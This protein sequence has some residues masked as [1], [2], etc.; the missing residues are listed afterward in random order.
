[1]IRW[2]KGHFEIEFETPERIIAIRRSV[3]ELI[4]EALN[5]TELWNQLCQQLPALST[6]CRGEF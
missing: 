2:D 4:H 5:Q 1:M 6:L 3:E